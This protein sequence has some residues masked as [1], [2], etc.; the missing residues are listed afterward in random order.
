MQFVN[1]NS[2]RNIYIIGLSLFLGISVP[3]YFH[4]YTASAST[5]PARTNA[6]WVYSLPPSHAIYTALCSDHL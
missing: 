2:M 4:E 6:G 1:K 3:Q 5:G